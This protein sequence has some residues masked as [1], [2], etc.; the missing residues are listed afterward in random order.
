MIHLQP[1]L[2]APSSFGGQLTCRWPIRELPYIYHSTLP[3]NLSLRHHSH[4]LQPSSTFFD[5]QY[6]DSI[7]NTSPLTYQHTLLTPPSTT[8]SSTISPQTSPKNPSHTH[9]LVT[10]YHTSSK[11]AAFENDR[12]KPAPASKPSPKTQRVSANPVGTDVAME[13]AP[14]FEK[15]ASEVP[16]QAA[17]YDQI[18]A[19]QK[20]FAEKFRATQPAKLVD[21]DLS[22]A[23]SPI[24]EPEVDD[25]ET[26]Y[27]SAKAE[28]NRRKR[29]NDISIEEEIKIIKLEAEYSAHQRKAEADRQYEQALSD[30]EGLFVAMSDTSVAPPP[31]EMSENEGE[32][33]VEKTAKRKRG[34]AKKE[35]PPAKKA[36]TAASKKAQKALSTNLFEGGVD[37]AVK[38]M[39]AKAAKAANPKKAPAKTNPKGKKHN[40]VG[41]TNLASLYGADVFGDTAA[42][43]GLPSQPKFKDYKKGGRDAALKQLMASVPEEST[44]VA[45]HDVKFLTKVS[46]EV[47]SS[48]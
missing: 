27:Q 46:G 35:G 9:H 39:R 17:T 33:L 47:S 7:N 34:T 1:G 44:G 8:T 14:N 16:T 32:E 29:S 45:K 36:K 48:F 12:R 18:K 21:D 11:M 2:C 4:T 6:F 22:V 5:L 42:V 23:A 40:G 24:P 41:I 43:A 37:N 15:A 26:R 30:D 13:T 28:Y 20:R 3:L 38:A 19:L 10:H 31:I 25:I